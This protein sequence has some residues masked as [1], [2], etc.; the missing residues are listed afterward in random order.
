MRAVIIANPLAGSYTPELVAEVADCCR[1]RFDA[2]TTLQT[3]ALGD[4][5]RFARS[6]SDGSIV[7]A[8]GG[9]GTAREVVHGLAGRN[10]TMFIVPAG[11][12][13]S[14]YRSFWGELPWPE[15]LNLALADPRSRRRLLDLAR[16]SETRA[17]VLAGAC[18]G[19]PPQAI[20]LASTLT[21]LTG[22][23]RYEHALTEL[24]GTFRPYPGRVTVDGLEVHNGLTMLA[25]VGGSRYRGG[26]FEVLPHSV[27]DDGLLDVCVIGGEHDPAEM[28]TLARA[29]EHVLRPGVTYARGRR[30]VIERTDSH[31]VWFEHDGEVLPH[32]GSR[33]TLEVVPHA[34][35]IF[36]GPT[37]DLGRRAA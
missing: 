7:L 28:L 25:N 3:T 19:F 24:A 27:I 23:A 16:L 20:H 18:T 14:C 33:F 17:L 34:V 26:Q 35:P 12:A 2:V 31:P 4:A 32:N 13:N 29:G 6:I 11:T 37:A 36:V 5:T 22:R 8:V 9:D 15:A 21:D 10:A 1:P 30:I